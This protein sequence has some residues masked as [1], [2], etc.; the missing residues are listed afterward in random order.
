MSAITADA[1]ARDELLAKLRVLGKRMKEYPI[2]FSDSMVPAILDGRKT[3][4]RRIVRSLP[5]EYYQVVQSSAGWWGFFTGDE[6]SGHH[7]YAMVKC[8]FGV[9]G[10]RLWVREAWR[11]G[12]AAD[13]FPPRTL[14]TCDPIQYAADNATINLNTLPDFGGWSDRLR[15]PLHMPRWA[16]RL[17][18]EVVSVRAERLHE[19]TEEDAERE[20]IDDSD[21]MIGQVSHPYVTAFASLWESINGH[22]SWAQNPWV[23]RIEFRVVPA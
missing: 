18:L 15:S 19:V 1:V 8:P 2:M 4:T 13:R 20:G 3:V 7:A 11:T 23:W 12:K 6:M 10:D 14:N 22:G 9:P 16:S 21:A 5:S 17:T